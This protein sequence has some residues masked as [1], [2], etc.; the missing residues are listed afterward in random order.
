M[1]T[2]KCLMGGVLLVA[3]FVFGPAGVAS[4]DSPNFGCRD[5]W[6]KAPVGTNPVKLAKDQNGDGWVCWKSVNGTGNGP[7]TGTVVTDNNTPPAAR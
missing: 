4:A 2:A 7:K 5:G 3:G 1:K 6:T